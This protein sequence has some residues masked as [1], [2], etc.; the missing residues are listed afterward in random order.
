MTR[1]Y[2]RDY[3]LVGAVLG[4]VS[5]LYAAEPVVIP[6]W[7]KGTPGFESRRTEPEEAQ[8]Y[9]VKNIHNP[10]L[11]VYAPPK[12]KA[13]G[14][15]VIVCPGGGHRLLVINSEGVDA[16]QFFNSIGVTAFV[17]KYRLAREPNSPYAVET[18]SVQDARRALRLVRS[19]AAEFGIDPKRL[20]LVG[21]SAGGEV[22][23]MTTWSP[24]PP[25]PAPDAIDQLS[26]R[27][28]FEIFIYPGP[29]GF[30]TKVASDAPP[31]FFVC[32]FED[33][34]PAQTISEMLERYRTAGV[35]VE[36]H[37]YAKGAHAFNMGFHS[38]FLSLRGWPQRAAEWM[39]DE[40]LLK[41]R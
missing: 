6:L 27:P 14:A 30:P 15:A 2:L 38:E 16:A 21:F 1:R 17:L 40:G 12:E 10:S 33:H 4:M 3:F 8:D 7:A 29:I 18:H 34:Q 13:N 28:D 23:A 39:L 11:T 26:A 31:A 36:V 37:V 35:P 22:A 20:G 25:I 19:R 41:T 5:Y 32:A 9:W 24:E